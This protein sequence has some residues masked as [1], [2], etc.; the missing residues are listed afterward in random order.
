MVVGYR[1]FTIRAFCEPLPTPLLWGLT[2]PS[3][4]LFLGSWGAVLEPQRVCTRESALAALC[5]SCTG[6]E[7]SRERAWLGFPEPPEG[8]TRV[9]HLQPLPDSFRELGCAAVGPGC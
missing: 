3:H 4:W 7:T 6:G 1:M 8:S 9:E 5:T 2:P